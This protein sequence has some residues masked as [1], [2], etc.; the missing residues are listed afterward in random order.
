M[1]G[2]NPSAITVKKGE[3]VTW[4]NED[5]NGAHWPASSPHPA[6]TD[7]PEFDPKA[8]IAPGQSWSFK[9]DRVGTWHYHDHLN[10][11][12]YGYGTVTVTE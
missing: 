1:N 6:H 2:W 9:F 12:T 10:A 5:P 3:T 7:Y 11:S 4:I 8:P